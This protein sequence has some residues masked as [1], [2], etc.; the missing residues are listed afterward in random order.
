MPSPGRRARVA[1]AV[2]ALALF[3]LLI[4]VATALAVA[5][6]PATGGEAIPA[7]EAG[8]G[9]YSQL[10]GPVIAESS[11]GELA[12]H[13]TTILNAPAGFRFNPKAGSVSV[14][15]TTCD[16]EGQLKVTTSQ[17]KLTVTHPSTVPDC[18]I[19]FVGLQVQPT[20]GH[21]LA[22]G[23]ITKTGTSAAPGDA[24]YGT[25]AMVPGGV[26][27]LIYLTQPSATDHGGTTFVTQPR[28]LVR[29]QFGNNIPNRPV[30]LSIEQGPRGS[31]LTCAPNPVETNGG[32]VADFSSSACR[33][34]RAGSY[35]LGATSGGVTSYSGT[36]RVLVGP[37]TQFVFE[38]YP[39]GRT[40]PT[41]SSQPRVAIADAGGNTVTSYRTIKVT[42]AINKNAKMFSC[43][44]YLTSQ[45]KHGVATFSGCKET[46]PGTGYR[47]TAWSSIESATGRAFTVAK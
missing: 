36:F 29:D 32:G 41:L 11:T 17:A 44:G 16:L 3:G 39:K 43:T 33:I 13:S 2:L 27:E 24:Y 7:D 1:A 9:T 45:T 23:P 10:A 4:P 31:H 20:S 12:L 22:A 26:A 42:I 8:T 18:V 47:L 6:V 46:V 14:D 30:A 34:D 37:A 19:W 38:A 25:L 15:V 40:K 35:R 21:G 28:V 5:V